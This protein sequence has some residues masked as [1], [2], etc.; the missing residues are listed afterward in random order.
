MAKTE[1]EALGLMA[2]HNPMD[3]DGE[4]L[5]IVYIGEPTNRMRAE[6]M[7]NGINPVY[8][9]VPVQNAEG[10]IVV[11][12]GCAWRAAGKVDLAYRIAVPTLAWDPGYTKSVVIQISEFFDKELFGTLLGAHQKMKNARRHRQPSRRRTQPRRRSREGRSSRRGSQLASKR[13]R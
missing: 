13:R 6:A 12:D 10:S 1:A 11:R 2:E 4:P 8:C 9:N 3:K 5:N 7:G